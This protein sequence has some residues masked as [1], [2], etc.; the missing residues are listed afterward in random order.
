MR[1]AGERERTDCTRVLLL[2]GNFV[3]VDVGVGPAVLAKVHGRELEEAEAAALGVGRADGGGARATER[4]ICCRVGEVGGG[5]HGR[6]RGGSHGLD[7]C[8]GGVRGGNGR[9]KGEEVAEGAGE[10]R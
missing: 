3:P 4:V 5:G 6:G 10:Q 9:G 2:D 8:L 1:D 7:L